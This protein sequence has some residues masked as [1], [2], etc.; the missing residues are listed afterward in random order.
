MGRMFGLAE[1]KLRIG[2]RLVTEDEMVT[3]VERYPLTDSA[4]Y[5]CQMGSTFQEPIDDDDATADDE[6]G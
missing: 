2:G 5:T 1:L 3:L 4:M 6:D